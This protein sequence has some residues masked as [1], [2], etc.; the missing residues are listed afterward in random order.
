MPSSTTGLEDLTGNLLKLCGELVS[1]TQRSPDGM[2]FTVK[3]SHSEQ[4][5]DALRN[6]VTQYNA[7]H[8][9]HLS[10][11]FPAAFR[12]KLRDV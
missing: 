4:I 3:M 6:Y 11:T 10:V 12:F 7:S 9:T 2:L 1:T 8:K 5:K